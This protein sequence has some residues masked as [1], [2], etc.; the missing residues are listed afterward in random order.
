M[1]HIT[2]CG[3][4]NTAMTTRRRRMRVICA[5]RTVSN[6][7]RKRVQNERANKECLTWAC[8][9]HENVCTRRVR[10]G[11]ACAATQRSVA[12]KTKSVG[13]V[14][15]RFLPCGTTPT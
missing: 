8:E 13:F 5:C 12:R 11:M 6:D 3:D 15:A 9:Q 1:G 14:L 10:E 4:N 2:Q 7:G